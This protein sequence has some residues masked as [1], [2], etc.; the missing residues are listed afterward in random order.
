MDLNGL[1]TFTA[2]PFPPSAGGAPRSGA[3]S[4]KLISVLS[5]S[6]ADLEIRDALETL[7]ARGVSNTQETRRNLRLDVQKEV[8]N[9]DGEILKEFGQVA[10]VC[11][12]HIV[13]RIPTDTGSS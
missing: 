6:Y 13:K 12:L 10:Q 2:S 7:D 4:N 11:G 1:S 5:T 3:L 8:I 9:C